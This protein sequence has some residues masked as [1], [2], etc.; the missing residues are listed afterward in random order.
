MEKDN[1]LAIKKLLDL[2]DSEDEITKA[3]VCF[4]LG[5]FSRLHP[6]SKTV[7][8]SFG[9]KTKLMSL[10]EHDSNIIRENALIAVQK[11]MIYNWKI[12]A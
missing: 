1:F 7:L 10:I 4:D 3:V 12:I 11:L 9:G 6:F 5:E 2:L 8:E